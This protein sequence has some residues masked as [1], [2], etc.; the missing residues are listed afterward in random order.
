MTGADIGVKL[1]YDCQREVAHL[2]VDKDPEGNP[3]DLETSIPLEKIPEFIEHVREAAFVE[4]VSETADLYYEHVI[5]ILEQ[6]LDTLDAAAHLI[7]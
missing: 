5:E 4:S 1:F 6:L 3:C 7:N 2:V